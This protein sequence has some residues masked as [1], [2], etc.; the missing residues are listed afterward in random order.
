M[1][2]L[3]K[4]IVQ[5]DG[6]AGLP[7]ISV[8]YVGSATTGFLAPIRTFFNA[9]ATTMPSPLT[10]TFPAAG[11]MID[12]ATGTLTGGWTDTAAA[13]V[14]CS[15]SGSYANG[16]GAFVRWGTGQ[17]VNGRKVVGKTFLV[18]ISSANYD[19]Q[20]NIGSGGL[21]SMQG[22]ATALVAASVLRIWHRPGSVSGGPGSSWPVN[23]GTVPDKVS[24]LQTRKH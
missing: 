9:M 2:D 10:W 18:P 17:I 14:T 7:G 11:D 20:G 3:K 5:W 4:V 16:V 8:F 13:Q 21:G 6:L 23:S 15:G 22:A 12:E 19:A 1:A 24:W